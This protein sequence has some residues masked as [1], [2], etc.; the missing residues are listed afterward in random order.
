MWLNWLFLSPL[1]SPFLSFGQSA[2]FLIGGK[3]KEVKPTPILLRSGDVIV[4]SSEARLSY[5]GVPRVLPPSEGDQTVPASL[6]AETLSHG[7]CGMCQDRGI[8]DGVSE[9][10]GDCGVVNGIP[11]N[12]NHRRTLLSAWPNFVS[13]LSMSRININI[14]QV[15][16]ENHRFWP[17]KIVRA[18]PYKCGLLMRWPLPVI[19]LM[20]YFGDD[21]Y[22]LFNCGDDRYLLF[23]TCHGSQLCHRWRWGGYQKR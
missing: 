2:I 20:V 4:M 12:C 23:Q 17:Q 11:R 3:S 14:R 18:I 21:H 5:H 1:C 13:Y 6:S 8:G 7:W 22:L 15:I 16:S 10:A 19:P 9:I